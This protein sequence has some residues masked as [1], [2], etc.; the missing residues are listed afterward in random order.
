MVINGIVLIIVSIIS[1]V[2]TFIL[3]VKYEQGP[4]KS[5][6]LLSLIVG[7]IF[8]LF[9]S[10]VSEYLTRK[11]PIAFIGASFAGMSSLKKIPNIYFYGFF[12]ISIWVNIC[13]HK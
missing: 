4:I 1:A 13:K 9:P 3:S 6:A 10:I 12:W 11:I 5:S 7:L 2:A 8:Y